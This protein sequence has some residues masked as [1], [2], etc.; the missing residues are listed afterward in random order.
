MPKEK[1]PV[2]IFR[3][4]K[5]EKSYVFAK[6]KRKISCSLVLRKERVRC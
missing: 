6:K 2:E 3:G 5:E 4:L 1:Y